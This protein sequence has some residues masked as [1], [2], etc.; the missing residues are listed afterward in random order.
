M[1]KPRYAV[2][3]V[4]DAVATSCC[5]TEALRALGLR[6][7]GGNHRT[8]KRLIERYSI[9]VDHFDPNAAR[10]RGPARRAKPLDEVLVESS[11]YNRGALKRR[12]FEQG[13]KVRRCELCGQ[14]E[15]WRGRPMALILDH[16]NGA[17]TDNR[18]E[19]LRIVCPNCAATLET[20]CGRKNRVDPDPRRC[21][22]C[23]GEFI[24]RYSTHRYC[25]PS[26]ASAVGGPECRG[27]TDERWRDRPTSGFCP[28]SNR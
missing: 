17:A 23:G 4:R 5:L 25:S 22:H 9:P 16:I 27:R 11:N 8:L 6:P 1:P 14:G 2:Q 10:A 28:T 20:H 19:N 26:A 7:A 21:L 18:I 3:Q 15:L 24:P 12:L 13:L